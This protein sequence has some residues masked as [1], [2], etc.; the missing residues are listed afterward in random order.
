[1]GTNVIGVDMGGTKILSAV[2]DAEGNILGTAKV[3]NQSGRRHICCKLI[4]LPTLYGRQSINQ[5]LP[6]IQFRLSESAR[7]DPLTQPQGLSFSHP[8]S[9][10]GMCH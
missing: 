1:M 10:G 2:I 5:M 9:V 6:R 8:T 4:E 7:R 3:P